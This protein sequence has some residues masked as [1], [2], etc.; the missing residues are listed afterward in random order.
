MKKISA[1]KSAAII[2]LFMLLLSAAAF[3]QPAPQSFGY[4]DYTFKSQVNIGHGGNTNGNAWLELGPNSGSTKGILMP[5]GNRAAVTSP[6]IGLVIYDLTDH[7]L[8]QYNGT[9][10]E[11]VGT[12]IPP[13]TYIENRVIG[14]SSQS[15]DFNINGNGQMDRAVVGTTSFAGTEKFRVAGTSN[16]DGAVTL[17]NTL[18]YGQL[19]AD[20]SGSNGL[21][22]YNTITNHFRAYENGAWYNVGHDLTSP[23]VYFRNLGVTD[24][25]W[26]DDAYGQWTVSGAYKLQLSSATSVDIINVPLTI[27]PS[28]GYLDLQNGAKI[29]SFQDVNI[30]ANV[31]GHSINLK[32]A[33]IT[34]AKVDGV[35]YNFNV[36]N[37]LKF[38]GL[39]SDPTG[40]NGL[41]HYN[42][43][44]NKFKA[45]ENSGW[46]EIATRSSATVQTTGATQTIISTITIPDNTSG[47]LVVHING[48]K[49]DNTLSTNGFRIYAYRKASGSLTI[50]GQLLPLSD[51]TEGALST[52]SWTVVANG[53][54]NIDIKVTGNASTTINWSTEFTLTF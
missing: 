23:V 38:D 42:T 43:T 31:D 25:T 10:W 39:A 51:V 33:N 48:L 46:K 20:P 44:S 49:S 21:M 24:V 40:S 8:F 2:L 47:Q 27:T 26:Q 4:F 5:R 12:T 1:K 13:G 9:T 54:N 16:M 35:T 41:L 30:D 32:V 53:S 28:A 29:Q 6:T 15:A 34:L 14:A 3:C 52:T 11:A 50:T 7:K 36:T 22:Y 45:Y 18:K 19:S 37:G 17:G